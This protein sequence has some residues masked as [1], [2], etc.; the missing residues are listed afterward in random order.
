MRR[1]FRGFDREIEKLNKEKDRME[2]GELAEAGRRGN[3][4]ETSRGMFLQRIGSRKTVP[5]RMLRTVPFGLGHIFF[6]LN[7]AHPH[8]LL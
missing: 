7:S 6:S 4:P 2:K 1:K 3:T 5:R 8:S